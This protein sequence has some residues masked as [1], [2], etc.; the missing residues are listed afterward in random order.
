MI[1]EDVLGALSVLGFRP[2][3]VGEFGYQIVYEGQGIL[4]ADVE[5]TD[6]VNFVMPNVFEITEENKSA[7][8]YALVQLGSE[9]KYAQSYVVGDESVWLN[10]VH[11]VGENNKVAP[12]I[13]EHII[14]V[15]SYAAMKFH[16]IINSTFVDEG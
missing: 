6:S 16:F 10:Y 7:V 3:E 15:L 12:E 9:V 14:T 11:F 5:D 13:I 1:K 2:K 8:Y 4:Y